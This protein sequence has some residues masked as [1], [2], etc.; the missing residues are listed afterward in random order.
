MQLP[1]IPLNPPFVKGGRGDLCNCLKSPL[2]P[3][4]ER[5]KPMLTSNSRSFKSKQ[6]NPK[7]FNIVILYL[8]ISCY[9]HGMM[10][11]R[12]SNQQT[13]KRVSVA[14]R[15]KAQNQSSQRQSDQ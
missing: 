5:G 12:L 8:L 9:K 13:V 1:E 6:L 10:T 7:N 14:I 4:Y 3:L 2:I 11:I 15:H